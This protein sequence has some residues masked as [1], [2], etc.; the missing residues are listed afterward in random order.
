MAL[1]KCKECGS[2]VSSK[3][4]AC[5]NCGVKIKGQTGCGSVLLSLFLVCVLL[6]M[7][8]AVLFPKKDPT[9]SN[10]E[11]TST[12]DVHYQQSPSNLKEE[13]KSQIA[14]DF[15]WSKGGFGNIMEADVK[16]INSS[17]H[18]I[19]DVEIRSLQF[20]KSGTQI[21]RNTRT[22]YEIIEAGETKEFK[23]F[24]MGF[25]HS[26]SEGAKATITDFVVID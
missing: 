8:S 2:Q 21:D 17:G 5:P 4:G 20:G 12:R 19:K 9:S 6:W 14:L 26:Q 1:I 18:A 24:N 22:I 7:F 3:A 16:I 10:D 25:I 15:A 13:I 23:K 11:D